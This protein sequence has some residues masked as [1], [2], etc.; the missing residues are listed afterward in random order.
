MNMQKMVGTTDTGYD[1]VCVIDHVGFHMSIFGEDN[2]IVHESLF[3]KEMTRD[4]LLENIQELEKFLCEEEHLDATTVIDVSTECAATPTTPGE[5]NL[6]PAASELT[7][8]PKQDVPV[9]D[10]ETQENISTNEP[11]KSELTS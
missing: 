2:K 8:T 4:E 11:D 7:A 1:W 5:S 9:L 3:V 10:V 6:L